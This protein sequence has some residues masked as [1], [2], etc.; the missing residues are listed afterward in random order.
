[1]CNDKV[2]DKIMIYN[3]VKLCNNVKLKDFTNNLNER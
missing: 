3:N 1:M 2:M